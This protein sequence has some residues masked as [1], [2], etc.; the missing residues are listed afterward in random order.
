MTTQK[1]YVARKLKVLAAITLKLQN[2]NSFFLKRLN[3]LKHKIILLL[4]CNFSK[5][6]LHH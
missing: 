5:I 3:L 4:T 1:N 2:V 6:G